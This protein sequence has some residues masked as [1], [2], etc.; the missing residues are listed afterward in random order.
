MASVKKLLFLAIGTACL[1]NGLSRSME[2]SI[3]NSA[4]SSEII[5]T[6]SDDGGLGDAQSAGIDSDGDGIPDDVDNCPQHWNP[7]QSDQD[8]DAEGDV[9]DLNDLLIYVE[10]RDATRV[11]YQLETWYSSFHIYRGDMSTL[12]STGIYSQ[13]A[14]CWVT[15]GTFVD[16]TMPA[17]G[18]VAFYLVTGTDGEGNESSLGRDSAGQVRSND[19]FCVVPVDLCFSNAWCFGSYFCLKAWG[20]CP[21]AGQCRPMGGF[22]PAYSFPVCG[23]DGVTY[24]ND[25]FAGVAGVSVDYL[26]PCAP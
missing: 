5:E 6:A 1:S 16:G 2:P 11:D 7:Y 20:N 18:Q 13:E 23:C 9:C 19:N 4:W 3:R 22:C 21:G 14:F 15:G 10:L 17:T 8:A 24:S 12:R 26:G 25:C